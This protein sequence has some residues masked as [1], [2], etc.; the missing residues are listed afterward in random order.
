M[1]L[2]FIRL[3]KNHEEFFFLNF[4]YNL[5]A[6]VVDCWP[7]KIFTPIKIIYICKVYR[8]S[9]NNEDEDKKMLIEEMLLRDQLVLTPKIFKFWYW[10]WY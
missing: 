6:I 10:F 9:F 3:K 4:Q 8:L 1:L 7:G 2:K 5:Y